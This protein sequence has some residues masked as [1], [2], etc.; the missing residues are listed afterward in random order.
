MILKII[1]YFP[2]FFLVIFNFHFAKGQNKGIAEIEKALKAN[3][4]EQAESILESTVDE[5]SREN[6][7]DSLVNYIVYVGKIA[8]AKTDSR[9]AVEKVTAFI[10]KIKSFL[11]Q[12][13]TI[14]QTYIQAGEFYGLI[15]L[16]K[17]G[18]EADLEALK[19]ITAT[20]EKR[21]AKLALIENNLSIFAQRMGD[22]NLSISHR[23]QG[24]KYLLSDPQP[25][26]ENLYFAYNGMGAA[27]WYISKEDSALYYYQKALQ[28]LEKS[29]Q[30][31][32][33]R[34]YRPAIV[35]NNLAGLYQLEGNASAAIEAMKTTI[36]NIMQFLATKEPNPKKIAAIPFQFEATDNLAGIY[37]ELGDLKKAGELLEYSYQQKQK[38]LKRDNPAIFISQI[39]LG[40]LYFSKR[41][42]TQLN[43]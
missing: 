23:R 36:N 13:E 24:L 16:N 40:Q 10:K 1:K 5:Y 7:P 33:N 41:E 38:N 32:M 22:L 9:H 15:G 18:Y 6:K 21:N 4:I 11:P 28:A 20:T 43:Q 34:F 29:P 35:L 37:K 14:E 8:Q 3:K 39:L 19:Y 26:N 31:P 27:M 12:Q 25:N 2:A 30:T 17:K 42:D